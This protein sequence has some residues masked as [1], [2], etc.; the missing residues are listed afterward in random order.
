MRWQD[1]PTSDRAEQ[2]PDIGWVARDVAATHPELYRGQPQFYGILRDNYLAAHPM[3]AQQQAWTNANMPDIAHIG[4]I[5]DPADNGAPDQSINARR[6][7][8]LQQGNTLPAPN[9]ANP[10]M[11]AA[12][13]VTLNSLPAQRPQQQQFYGG[14]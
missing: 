14:Y 4:A 6:N 3:A 13:G 5:A 12:P 1:M 8:P 9:W 10:P 7:M 11:A 2:A